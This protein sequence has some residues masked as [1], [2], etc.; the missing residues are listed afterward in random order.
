MTTQNTPENRRRIVRA[1]GATLMT[2]TIALVGCSTPTGSS[3]QA[4]RSFRIGGFGVGSGSSS[5]LVFS[6]LDVQRSD[7]FV[8][9]EYTDLAIR[10]DA[11]LGFVEGPSPVSQ[12]AYPGDENPDLDRLRFIFLRP[13]PDRVTYFRHER[14]RH[15]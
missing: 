9:S 6:S 15:R 2:T 8:P 14:G 4:Q 3:E 11:R 5:E 12:V 13:Q 1:L 7:A 10:N